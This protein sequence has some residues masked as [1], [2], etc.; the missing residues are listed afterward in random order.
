MMETVGGH[1]LHR[2]NCGVGEDSWESLDCREIKPVNPKGNQSWIFIG[3]TDAEAEAPIFWPPDT[4][5]W[6]SLEKTLMLGKTEGR[7]RRGQQKMR[8]LDGITDLM[9][10]SLSK[11]WE[12]VMDRE[13]WHAAVHEVK[14]NWTQLVT[15]LNWT[16]IFFPWDHYIKPAAEKS[17]QKQEGQ[18]SWRERECGGGRLMSMTQ[19]KEDTCPL[20]S[21][22]LGSTHRNQ[23]CCEGYDT[24]T[25]HVVMDLPLQKRI[26][27][28]LWQSS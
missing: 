17:L 25:T 10:M 20:L 16:E 13:V 21:L 23:L 11:L 8:W 9:D 28:L 5:N 19:N 1:L 24:L 14:K 22:R 4:K 3:R 7:R 2:T 6:N 26:T 27:G 12:L 18:A 15:E